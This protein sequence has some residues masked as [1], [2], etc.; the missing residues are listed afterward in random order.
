MNRTRIFILLSLLLIIG[1]PVQARRSRR[2]L[3]VSTPMAQSQEPAPTPTAAHVDAAL[4]AEVIHVDLLPTSPTIATVAAV[5]APMPTAQ[6]ATQIVAPADIEIGKNRARAGVSIITPGKR[7]DESPERDLPHEPAPAPMPVG[8]PEQAMAASIEFHFENTD[9]EVLVNQMAQLFDITFITDD[10]ITPLPQ[11][12]KSL[13]GNKISF[14]TNRLLTRQEAWNLFTSFLQLAGFSV[15]QEANPKFLRI[16]SLENARK[17]PLP[18]FIGVPYTTLPENDEL[19]RY[20]YFVENSPMD[21]IRTMVDTLRST[22]SSLALL[23]DLKAFVLTD[24]SYN[25]RSLMNIVKE[26]DRITMP[27]SMAVIKLRR[28]DAAE[29]KRLYDALT[30]TDE[31]SAAT[32]LFPPR[33]ASAAQYFPD[34]TRVIAEPR[35]NSL[36]L[37]GP[38]DALKRIEDFVVNYVDVDLSQPYS[39]LHVIQ[40]KYADANAIADIM[41]NVTQFGR[42]TEAGKAGGVRG[43]DKYMRPMFFIAEP[44]TNRLIVKAD[45]EDFLKAQEVITLLDEPQ[46]QVAI[47]VLV[48]SVG[49]QDSR[50]LGAQLRTKIPDVISQ[51]CGNKVRF[52]TSGLF[53]GS[54][55][56]G[57]VENPDGPGINRLLGNLVKLVTNAPAGNTVLALGDSLGVWGILQVLQAI[58]NTQVLSNPFLVAINKQKATVSVGET[59]RVITGTVIGTQQI[60]TF[61]DENANL[62]V[63]VTPQINSDGMIVLDILVSLVQFLG[64]DD[65]NTCTKQSRELKTKIIAANKEVIALGGFVQNRTDDSVIKVPILGDIPII[66]WLFKNRQKIQVKNNLLILI[67]TRIIEP[68]LKDATKIFTQ[69]RIDEYHEDIQAMESP[70]E[71]RDPVHRWYFHTPQ[72]SVDRTVENFLVDRKLKDKPASEKND[73]VGSSRSRIAVQKTKEGAPIVV[74]QEK[75]P[76]NINWEPQLVQNN[77]GITQAV[78][79]AMQDKKQ[80]LGAAHRSSITAFFDEAARN[81]KVAT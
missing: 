41:T 56:H 50:E 30:Q 16:T 33:K 81:A 46:P 67:S 57:I 4:K 38:S 69:E 59:R 13:R 76:A 2:A 72:N 54:T 71:M 53:A 11:G 49:L 70:I 29:V 68:M 39:P 15:V 78:S 14:K 6:I 10:A 21:T 3:R 23:Q 52:Q 17:S 31:R 34:S 51:L 63:T 47:E 42:N 45:Y 1:L 43:G 66:G 18:T 80:P 8:E 5:P 26:L 58:S 24:R 9:L 64:P 65:P 60:D 75:P 61:G 27:Q 12:T 44:E 74:K 79:L 40:L 25:I 48:L 32:R 73:V 35:T 62:E 28:A 37:L 22:S 36:I 77:K 19:I 55:A 7:A 20:V